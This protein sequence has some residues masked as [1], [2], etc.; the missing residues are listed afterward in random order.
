[1][2]ELAQALGFKDAA[3][4]DDPTTRNIEMDLRAV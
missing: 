4:Q 2:L 1:M 3:L